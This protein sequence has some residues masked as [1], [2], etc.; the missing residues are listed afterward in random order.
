MRILVL[1]GTRFIGRHLVTEALVR[2]H[3]MT[4]LCRAR[5]PSPFVGIVRHVVTDR[6]APT[7]EAVQVLGESWDAVI[8]T[9][10]T[11][12]DDLRAT[13]P[14]LRDVST[15]VLLSTCGVYRPATR[16]L[17]ERSPTIQAELTNPTRA[18]ASR[19]LRC[20]RYLTR[21]IARTGGRLL[22]AR[23]GVV[24]GAY[25]YSDRLAYWLERALRGGELLV[26]MHP[27]QPLQLI[28]AHDV[29][30]FLIETLPSAVAGVVN[31][32]GPRRTAGDII[33]QVIECAGGHAVP[34][35][36]GED[37]ALHH[38]LRPWTQ[39]PLWLPSSSPERALMNVDSSQAIAA[40]LTYQ[41]LADT[42][43]D[44]LTWQALRRGWSQRW[45]DHARELELL[46]QWQD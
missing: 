36:V 33:D 20:E 35:W 8:D 41:P 25:D 14:L 42:I 29:A 40:G 11:D 46:R 44:C 26:P 30:C 2:D 3:E 13:T 27:E 1:G 4:L 34:R 28:D 16:A 10:A 12:V 32:A 18:S 7:E 9:C 39:V 31:V 6:R 43:T 21:H 23:L 24:T 38:G 45:L 22:V 37:F 15:Y 5:T 19:K 17:T